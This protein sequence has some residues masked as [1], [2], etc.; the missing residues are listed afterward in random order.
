MIAASVVLPEADCLQGLYGG[1]NL[2]NDVCHHSEECTKVG[3]RK[4]VLSPGRSE[5]EQR[6]LVPLR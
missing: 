5:H 4:S 3:M 6:R 1:V 2:L